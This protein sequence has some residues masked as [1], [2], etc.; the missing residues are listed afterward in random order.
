MSFPLKKKNGSSVAY[1]KSIYIIICVVLF[2]QIQLEN[3]FPHFIQRISLFNSQAIHSNVL[4]YYL[5]N[6][7]SSEA[8]LDY[9]FVSSNYESCYKRNNKS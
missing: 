2:L 8:Y 4:F 1:G 5:L 9:M 6:M 3:S 7:Y